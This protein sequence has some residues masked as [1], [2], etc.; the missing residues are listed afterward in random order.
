MSLAWGITRV[1][2]VL[3]YYGLY[4]WHKTNE[5]ELECDRE[6]FFKGTK[7][8]MR[9]GKRVGDCFFELRKT[10]RCSL[11]FEGSFT[12]HC[13]SAVTFDRW[14]RSCR[15]IVNFMSLI[16][17]VHCVKCRPLHLV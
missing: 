10:I 13:E 15:E 16:V 4:S 17:V 7:L 6:T 14:L 2:T 12:L 9:N 11:L 3:L 1:N 5:N 8:V